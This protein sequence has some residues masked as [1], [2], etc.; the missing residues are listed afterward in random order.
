[1]SSVPSGLS[2]QWA[3][4]GRGVSVGTGQLCSASLVCVRS[5]LARH[6]HAAS[7][8][9]SGALPDDY[10]RQGA[11]T[12]VCSSAGLAT[13]HYSRHCVSIMRGRLCI[14]CPV[15]R[16]TVF[17]TLPVSALAYCAVAINTAN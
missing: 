13:G 16:T 1:M 11:I 10:H 8:V 12:G 9:S 15:R 5:S 14:R 17:S 6:G 4:R 2:G 3:D 7:A